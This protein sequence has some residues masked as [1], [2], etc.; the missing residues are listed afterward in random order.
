MTPAIAF[1]DYRFDAA[2]DAIRFSFSDGRRKVQG[3]VSREC[4]EEDFSVRTDDLKDWLSACLQ[5]ADQIETTARVL[6]H[7]GAPEP[8]VVRSGNVSLFN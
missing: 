3:L 1:N 4:L 6:W 7:E 2:H 5:F 8:V